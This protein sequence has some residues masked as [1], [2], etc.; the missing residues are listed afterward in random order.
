MQS[1]AITYD[2]AFKGAVAPELSRRLQRL[3]QRSEQN[4]L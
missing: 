4:K 1:G 3:P 2:N